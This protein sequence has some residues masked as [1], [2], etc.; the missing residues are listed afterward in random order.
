M[1]GTTATKFGGSDFQLRAIVPLKEGSYMGIM[2]KKMETTVYGL[3]FR[4]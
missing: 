2:E 1:V 4:V 3:G